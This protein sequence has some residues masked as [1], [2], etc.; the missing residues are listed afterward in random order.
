MKL[1]TYA[2]YIVGAV[3]LTL[4]TALVV[5]LAIA[6]FWQGFAERAFLLR[7][8]VVAVYVYGTTYLAFRVGAHPTAWRAAALALLVLP[9]IV[10]V[11]AGGRRSYRLR[12]AA[13]T[14]VLDADSSARAEAR[15][16]LT[17]LGPRAGDPPHVAELLQLLRQ[18]GDD[19]V[20]LRGVELL[21]ATSYQ[22]RGVLDELRQIRDETADDP[23]RAELHAAVVTAIGQVNPYENG[24]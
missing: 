12:D 17:A 14:A 13:R 22:S 3:Y 20:R 7:F 6:G 1:V 21:G 10:S 9:G 16:A 23:L 4:G 15:S 19:E 24:M 18:A 2:A 5:A 11:A 8:A